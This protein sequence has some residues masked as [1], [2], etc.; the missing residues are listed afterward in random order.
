ME[1]IEELLEKL[2]KYPHS[3]T[4]ANPYLEPYAVDN[5]RHYFEYMFNHGG[6]RILLVGEAPGHRGCRITGIPFTSGRAFQKI[7]HPLLVALKNKIQLPHIE[8]ESTATIVWN[9]LSEK[10]TTPLF[11]NSFPFHPHKKGEV[12]GNREPTEAEVKFGAK[13]LRELHHIYKPEVIAGIG[14]KGVA[15]L[16]QILPEQ[17]IK[18]IRHPSYGGKSQFIEGMNSVI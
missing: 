11:W 17:T 10:E 14:Y 1:L 4:V 16:E 12:N 13:I 5:L 6:K 9:Y 3:D 7:P 15:A 8:T 2:A 18:Y